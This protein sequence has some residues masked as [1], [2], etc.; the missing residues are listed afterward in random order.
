MFQPQ[1]K[2]VEL[3]SS[4]LDEQDGSAVSPRGSGKGLFRKLSCWR[5]DRVALHALN[6]AGDPNLVLNF[7]GVGGR[8]WSVLTRHP[9]RLVLST[10]ESLDHPAGP[11]SGHVVEAAE[12]ICVLHPPGTE[13][14]SAMAIELGENSVDSIFCMRL[15]QQITTTEQRMKLLQEFHRIT[16]DTL[17]ISLWVDGNYQAWRRKRQERRRVIEGSSEPRSKRVVLPR[18]RIEEEFRSVGFNILTHF[19]LLPGY[20]MSR[21]Y[22]LRKST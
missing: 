18:E 17:I 14:V 20:A 12:R 9:N 8:Y 16:R 7:P 22:V 10:D 1:P 4:R 21:I 19:D 13:P 3:D 2:L 15:L 5:E 6:V 11:H